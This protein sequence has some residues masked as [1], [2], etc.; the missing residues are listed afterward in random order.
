M[1]DKKNPKHSLEKNRVSVF[2]IGLLAAGSF[3]LAAFTYV[4]PLETEEAKIAAQHADVTYVAQTE[5]ETPEIEK[6]AVVKPEEQETST[7]TLDAT[8]TEEIS[9]TESKKEKVESGVS[10]E[11]LN[12]LKG[13]FEKIVIGAK[14]VESEIVPWPD[15]EAEF[16][17]GEVEMIKFIHSNL[18]YPEI[19][20]ITNEQGKVQISFVV[21]K[22]GSISNVEVIRG[23]Y[24]NLNREA[25]RIIRAFP[26]W[27]PAQK[28]G[29]D[30]RSRVNIPIIFTLQ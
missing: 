28:D 2:T 6:P 23:N 22:D 14:E 21:E 5:K 1:I 30:V 20:K 15:K 24:K 13:E 19:S 3:T 26:K 7:T 18:L 10:V 17:G 27:K 12:I 25:S 8:V 9:V 29:K 11:G 4:S 16:Y